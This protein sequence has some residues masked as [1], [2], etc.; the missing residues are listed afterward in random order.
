MELALQAL[1]N[2]NYK[3]SEKAAVA[4]DGKGYGMDGKTN[5]AAP[6]TS[7]AEGDIVKFAQTPPHPPNFSA[8]QLPLYTHGCCTS[9]IAILRVAAV[10]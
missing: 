9:D 4:M 6:S 8:H 3:L 2:R 7:Y 1:D 10:F 5:G